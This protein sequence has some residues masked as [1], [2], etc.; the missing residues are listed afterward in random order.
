M[1]A[2]KSFI[3]IDTVKKTSSEYL[4]QAACQLWTEAV[5]KALQHK[6]VRLD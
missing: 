1:I 2:D 4:S 3:S 5:V 6:I